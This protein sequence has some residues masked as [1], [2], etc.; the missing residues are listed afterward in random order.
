MSSVRS[1]SDDQT[2][3]I[4]EEVALSVVKKAELRIQTNQVKTT[5]TQ[6]GDW[7][8]ELWGDIYNRVIPANKDEQEPAQFIQ[9]SRPEIVKDSKYN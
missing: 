2:D 7:E 4:V 3:R 1:S 9:R 5:A 6:G 8:I